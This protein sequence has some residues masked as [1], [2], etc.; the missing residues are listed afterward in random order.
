VSQPPANPAVDA[1]GRRSVQ[2]RLQNSKFK[3]QNDFT[4]PSFGHLPSRRGGVCKE[5]TALQNLRKKGGAS[6]EG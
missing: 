6:A 1:Y 5:K 2:C 4:P 3:I